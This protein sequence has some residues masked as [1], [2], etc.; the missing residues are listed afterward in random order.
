MAVFEL[1]LTEEEYLRKSP[2][3]LHL[4]INYNRKHRIGILREVAAEILGAGPSEEENV[5]EVDS[6]S[7]I[8]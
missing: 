8:F 2:R 5:Q 1:G 6:F 4:L 7:E 3:Q